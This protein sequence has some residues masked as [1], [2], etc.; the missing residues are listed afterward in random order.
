MEKIQ[1]IQMKEFAEKVQRAMTE[2]L[3]EGYEVRL[4][5]IQ[6]NNG[7]R[8][9][10]LLI[11]TEKQNVSPTIY[12]KPFWEAYKE[13]VTLADLVKKNLQIYREGTPG[14]N[15]DMAFFRDFER[16][17][18]R[19]CYRLI[20]AKQNKELL[21]K[22]PH[23]PFLDLAICYYYAY[24]GETLG[25]GTI[26]IYN[27]H[28]DMWD[29]CTAELMRLAQI[30]TPNFFPWECNSMEYVINT[31]MQQEERDSLAF[32]EEEQRQLL[33]EIPM[34][35]LSNHQRVYGAACILYPGVLEEIAEKAEANLFILP[36]SVHEVI[37]LPDSR[38]EDPVQ[39][40]SM[41]Y[42]VN[43]TQLEPEEVLSDSLYYYERLEKNIKMI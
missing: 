32:V 16:V 5:E 35:I 4:Q 15:V 42:E 40:K 7:V 27:T 23:I 19:I 28:M 43:R 18:D 33:E 24:E 14:E 22:I 3:G 26:L 29:T 6:K 25:S 31:L 8:L 41:I 11:L 2:V 21:E 13:G 37:L 38:T 12:L 9:Q 10:G 17:K 30:N 1:E 36:S 34:S 20:D 39:L